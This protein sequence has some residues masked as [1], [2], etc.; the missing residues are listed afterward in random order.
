MNGGFLALTGSI[1]IDIDTLSLLERY[2]NISGS[3]VFT[4]MTL[5]GLTLGL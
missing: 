4:L 3:D 2:S 1:G 5:H